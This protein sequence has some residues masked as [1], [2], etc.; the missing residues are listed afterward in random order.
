M[1]PGQVL[2]IRSHAREIMGLF[3]VERTGHFAKYQIH[4]AFDR[5]ERR[6]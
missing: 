4:R 3:F 6:P 2:R 1:R 5:R